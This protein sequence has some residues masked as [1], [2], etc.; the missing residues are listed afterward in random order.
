[1][2]ATPRRRIS[3]TAAPSQAAILDQAM[4]VIEQLA[5]LADRFDDCHGERSV[6]IPLGLCRKA[7]FARL[8]ADRAREALI[9]EAA[10]GDA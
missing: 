7:R 2:I 3:D 6:T 4:P 8:L 5:E 9:S 10:L 1:M